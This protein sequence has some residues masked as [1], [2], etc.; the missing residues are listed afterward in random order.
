MAFLKDVA[1]D[2]M[3]LTGQNE[4]GEADW[5]SDD[6]LLRT[7]ARLMEVPPHA[8]LHMISAKTGNILSLRDLQDGQR[9]SVMSKSQLLR[10]LEE[11][12]GIEKEIIENA[13]RDSQ[14]LASHVLSFFLLF[15]VAA[16]LLV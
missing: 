3:A 6:H 4:P 8:L 9:L 12:M 2:I 10:T 1:S 13:C 14:I 16:L 5:A 11:R 15:G 7:T